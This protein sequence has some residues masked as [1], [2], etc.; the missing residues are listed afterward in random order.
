[1]L[2]GYNGDVVPIIPRAYA[3]LVVGAAAAAPA[4]VFELI[5][6]FMPTVPPPPGSYSPWA[7]ARPIERL[8]LPDTCA[9]LQCRAC[10]GVAQRAQRGAVGSVAFALLEDLSC[11]PTPPP[12][13]PHA[14]P[15]CGRHCECFHAR[16]VRT[17]LIDT[18]IWQLPAHA[19]HGHGR[20]RKWPRPA[21]A[22]ATSVADAHRLSKEAARLVGAPSHWL[23][24]RRSCV[25][26]AA[27]MRLP[28]M[29]SPTQ[30][31]R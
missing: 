3:S 10:T 17:C 7:S 24:L 25:P 5:V 6:V 20:E 2:V 1:M 18:R 28:R 13:R 31:W 22:A 30:L 12:R 8:V 9:E 11:A 4:D 29:F 16:P 26:L 21:Y 14:A 27:A 23:C 15:N 19:W